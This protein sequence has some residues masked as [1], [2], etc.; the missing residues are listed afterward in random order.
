MQQHSA[1]M[2]GVEIGAVLLTGGYDIPCG[3][4]RPNQACSRDWS[5]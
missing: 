2:N 5:S 3:N 1:A 4:P